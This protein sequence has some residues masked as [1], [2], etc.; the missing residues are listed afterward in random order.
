[1]HI[2]NLLATTFLCTKK[3]QGN[4]TVTVKKD[5]STRF[6]AWWVFAWK[7]PWFIEMLKCLCQ[8]RGTPVCTRTNNH[9]SVGATRWCPMTF[10]FLPVPCYNNH[11]GDV[12]PRA[13]TSWVCIK[14]QVMFFPPP[15]LSLTSLPSNA[16]QTGIDREREREGYREGGREA[17]NRQSEW[18]AWTAPL[19]LKDTAAAAC[20]R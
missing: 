7:Q 17:V 9:T 14:A 20:T 1:M 5:I 10:N 6:E 19:S 15:V 4:L 8:Q 12:K 18:H 11:R 2:P 16:A 3:K 13:C